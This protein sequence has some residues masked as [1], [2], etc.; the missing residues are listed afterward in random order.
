MLEFTDPLDNKPRRLVWKSKLH[1]LDKLAILSS[2]VMFFCR[3][4]PEILAVDLVD[5]VL[6]LSV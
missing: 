1:I 4:L 2:G 3:G 5:V 6:A